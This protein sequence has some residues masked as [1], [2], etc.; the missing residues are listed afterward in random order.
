VVL[1][2]VRQG[3]SEQ[4]ASRTLSAAIVVLV[5]ETPSHPI[6]IGAARPEQGLFGALVSSWTSP[7]SA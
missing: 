3:W 6:P 7:A 5:G 4:A 2:A 1:A